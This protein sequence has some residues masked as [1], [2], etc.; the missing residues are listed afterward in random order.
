MKTIRNL[1]PMKKLIFI[2]MLSL[3]FFMF[4]PPVLMAGSDN[5]KTHDMGI[6]KE[7]YKYAYPIDSSNKDNA[8]DAACETLAFDNY[9]YMVAGT[10]IEDAKEILDGT[11]WKENNIIENAIDKMFKI[12]LKI[13]EALLVV[14]FI[15]DLLE[16]STRHGFD[17]EQTIRLLIRYVIAKTLIENGRNIINAIIAIGNAMV[18]TVADVKPPDGV[19]QF[20]NQLGYILANTDTLSDWCITFLSF[21]PYLLCMLLNLIIL[22]TC[23]GRAIEIIVRGSFAPIGCIGMVQ[24]GFSG[25]GLQY[26][27]KFFA[28][29]I[30]GAV[31]VVIL[32]AG[33]SIKA[34]ILSSALWNIQGLSAL[35]GSLTAG[36]ECVLVC[37]T[38]V[39]V[40]MK[41]MQFSSEIAGA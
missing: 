36:F 22:A 12:L 11:K 13:G 16:K 21:I 30:Q 27:K 19:I 26:I 38:E 41:S 34:S 14:M 24:E 33:A 9:R 40:V 20:L 6:T 7:N 39:M 18:G 5:D 35:G 32:Y 17:F 4:L 37:L 3:S 2:L 28:V 25:R 8:V 10:V 15:L 31:I 29:C 23:Y 1:T